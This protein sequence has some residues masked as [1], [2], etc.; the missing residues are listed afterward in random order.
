MRSGVTPRRIPGLTPMTAEEHG[1]S[2][3]MHVPTGMRQ[4]A[5]MSTAQRPPALKPLS[6]GGRLGAL[7][8]VAF[9]VLFFLGTAMLDIPHGL[10]DE[11]TVAWWSESGNRTTA[12]VSMYCFTVAGLCFIAF[13]VQLRSRLLVAEGG[14]GTLTALVVVSG[15]VF[16]AMLLVAA[17]ARGL[18]GFAVESPWLDEPLPGPDTLRY[19]PQIGATALG[20]GG[21]LSAAVT[22]AT[23]SWL[24]L[25]TA[26]FPRWLAWLGFLA[27]LLIVAASATLSGVLALPAVLVWALATSVALWRSAR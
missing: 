4:E 11:K 6:A 17:M 25:R 1:H 16:V 24:I 26:V 14:T 7:A 13:L 15:A 27:T 23:A 12:V 18:I 2:V 10:S 5:M 3:F 22:I 19:L 8:G 9:A 21:L 20:V